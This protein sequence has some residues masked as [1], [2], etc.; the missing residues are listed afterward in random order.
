MSGQNSS[1]QAFLTA[2]YAQG[3]TVVLIA[4]VALSRKFVILNTQGTSAGTIAALAGA[5]LVVGMVYRLLRERDDRL[6]GNERGE[7]GDE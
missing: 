5:T 7:L 4:L 6:T 3:K 2:K 1:E